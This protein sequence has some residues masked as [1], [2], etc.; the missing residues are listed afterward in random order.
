MKEQ[1][2]TIILILGL[3][4]VGYYYSEFNHKDKIIN[5]CNPDL[6]INKP[7]ITHPSETNFTNEVY[8]NAQGTT[9]KRRNK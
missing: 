8:T 2:I 1:I 7:S 9:I 3:M 6:K 5:T 4:S